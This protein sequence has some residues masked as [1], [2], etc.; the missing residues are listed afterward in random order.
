MGMTR[1]K[2]AIAA[3]MAFGLAVAGCGGESESGGDGGGE[4]SDRIVISSWGGD[5]TK[6]TRENLAMPFTKEAGIELQMVDASGQHY[7]QVKAQRAAN[8]VTW[9]VIDSLD[10]ATATRMYAEGLLETVP[11][12][13]K[14]VLEENS[15]DGMVTD[16]GIMQSSINDTLVCDK[17][18]VKACP[19]TVADFFDVDRFPGKR[20]HYNDAYS[21]VGTALAAL[22]VEPGTAP[23]EAQV[24]EAFELIERVKPEF[25]T[26]WESADQSMQLVRSGE[27]PIA[28]VWNRPARVLSD[29]DQDR[30]EVSWD[31][32]LYAP[33]YD[34][35][36]K[37]APHVDRSWEY[38]KWYA[39]HPKNQAAWSTTTSY[40]V[41]NPAAIEQVAPEAR[42]WLPESHLDELNRGYQ[43]W[44]EENSDAISQRWQEAISG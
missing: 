15:A 18:K 12:D 44:W 8:R 38:L 17:T 30:Y 43:S 13:V 27:A 28:I 36:P 11:A 34:V 14:R 25:S 33:A 24:D 21:V 40:G 42:K 31:G 41:A 39:T 3:L 1:G 29:E 6:A 37:G 5:F 35:V 20:T 9:D 4:A 2:A 10:E 32:F 7:A 22:G 19:K 23:T 26:L 16:Y